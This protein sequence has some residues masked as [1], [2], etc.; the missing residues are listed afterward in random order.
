M[1]FKFPK[2]LKKSLLIKLISAFLFLIL[3]LIFK[4]NSYAQC[5]GYALNFNSNYV[6][7]DPVTAV[8]NSFTME[9]RVKPNKAIKGSMTASNVG[10]TGIGCLNYAVHP[11][12]GGISINAGAGISVGTN[13]VA[14]M[15]HT[16]Y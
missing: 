2:V 15:E 7:G 8:S 16:D 12:H 9:F 5:P 6:L 13:G 4:S 11:Y 10:Y 1:Q 14:I 3:S